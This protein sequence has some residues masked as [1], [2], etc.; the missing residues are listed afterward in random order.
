[1]ITFE[2]I[3]HDPAINE[4]I[5]RAAMSL[6]AM[7]YTEHGFTHALRVAG[8]AGFVL[9]KLGYPARDCELARIAGYMHDIGNLV[10]RCDHAQSGALMSFRILDNMGM[11]PGEL[12]TVIT[13]IGNHDEQTAFP[14]NP[15]SAAIILADKTDVRRSRVRNTKPSTFDIHDRVNYSVK[16]STVTV[17]TEM[18]C[19]S[20]TLSTDGDSFSALEFFEIFIERMM[21]CRRSCEKLDVDFN[22]YFDG[23][24]LS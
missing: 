19:I 4:F 11:D 16:N 17:D 9:E 24:L 12:A 1:M 22:A 6:D 21:L 7:G 3:R 20:L 23:K 2:Q 13:A 8:T 15:V 10:N 14:V 5:S 18:R